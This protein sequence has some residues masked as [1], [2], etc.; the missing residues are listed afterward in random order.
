MFR[1]HFDNQTSI[2]VIDALCDGCLRPIGTV[3]INL[4][5]SFRPFVRSMLLKKG[6]PDGVLEIHSGEGV[7]KI[8]SIY[9][10]QCREE[11]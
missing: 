8:A 9:C 5:K 3:T 10:I 4:P 11:M 2:A 1:G 7:D 6:D